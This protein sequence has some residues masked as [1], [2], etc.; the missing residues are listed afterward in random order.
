M[1]LLGHW[2]YTLKMLTHTARLPNR[3]PEPVC[4]LAVVLKVSKKHSF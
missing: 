1:E 3:K 4:S 2:V